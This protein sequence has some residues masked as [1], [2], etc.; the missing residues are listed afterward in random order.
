MPKRK[1]GFVMCVALVV[2]NMIGSGVFLLPASLAPL[3]WNSVYGWLVT[4]A[5]SLCLVVGADAAGAR[6]G[7]TA[8]PPSPIRPPPSARAPASS[9]PGATG[10]RAGSPMRRSPSPRSAI[11]RS[12]GPGWRR[13]AC[14]PPRRDRLLWL[15]TIVN[16]L[17]VRTA[18]GVQVADHPPQAGAAGRRHP[19]RGVAA[20]PTARRRSRP[21]D[22][23]PISAAG[24]R[25]GRDLRPVRHARLRKRDGGGRPGRESRAQRAAR[26]PD[27]HR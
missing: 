3:G 19:G 12:S 5:G 1:L 18:G 15:F 16:C 11:F 10:S 27:R 21:H 6:P 4:I 17:G 25:R 2:G 7:R 14:R 20:S 13:R 23:V 22:S 24:D 9:S 8:A 26:D